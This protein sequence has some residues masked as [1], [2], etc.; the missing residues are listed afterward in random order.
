[1]SRQRSR[2]QLDSMDEINITPM[3]DLVFL[4]LIVFIITTPLL[5]NTIDVS[6]PE[7]AASEMED[8][9]AKVVNLDKEGNL[10]IENAKIARENIESELRELFQQNPKYNMSLRADGS[11]PY[12]DV[13]KVLGMISKAGFKNVNLITIEPQ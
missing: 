1:M 6:P 9:N 13:I 12:E 10:Y 8:K 4:L 7:S 3:L 11:L 2:S 5:E